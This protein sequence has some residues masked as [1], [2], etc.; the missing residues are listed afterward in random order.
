MSDKILNKLDSIEKQNQ[1]AEIKYLVGLNEN[2]DTLVDLYF[3]VNQEQDKKEEASFDLQLETLQFVLV[4]FILND[5]YLSQYPASKKYRKSFL[6][7]IINKFQQKNLELNEHILNS[8]INLLKENDEEKRHF[9]V[10][11]SKVIADK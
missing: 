5:P 4:E 8:Y 11:F 6:K 1:L 9:I 7:N 3:K 2:A 10:Y